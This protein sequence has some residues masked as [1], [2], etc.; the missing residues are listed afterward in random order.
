MSHSKNIILNLKAKPRKSHWSNQWLT[1]LELKE[2]GLE[3]KTSTSDQYFHNEFKE[4]Q[5]EMDGVIDEEQA[6]ENEDKPDHLLDSRVPRSESL[7]PG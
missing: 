5:Q 6:Y 1:Y 2:I 7:R 4:H 3:E